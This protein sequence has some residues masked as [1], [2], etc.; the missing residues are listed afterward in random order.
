MTPTE[1]KAFIK[2]AFSE[3]FENMN[4]TEKMYAKY[5]SPNYVQY[6]DG[7]R[8]NYHDFVD[9]MK[10]LKS[11]LKSAKIT[12]KYMVVEGDKIATV[13]MAEGIKKD[14]KFVE[15]QVNA[16][17][18]IKNRKIVLCDELTHLIKGD[19]ADRNLGSRR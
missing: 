17:F 4:S 2:E 12:F 13:H 19:E 15:S 6:V 3:V 1:T 8:L 11:T 18:Q 5:F 9:H 10:A 16:L 7:K 14:G